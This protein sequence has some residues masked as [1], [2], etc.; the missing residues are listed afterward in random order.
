MGI[1]GGAAGL[2]VLVLKTAL[3]LR[4][5]NLPLLPPPSLGV[6]LALLMFLYHQWKPVWVKEIAFDV[7]SNVHLRGN[8]LMYN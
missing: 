4:V 5:E 8:P 2:A 3:R 6:R 7:K 1:P